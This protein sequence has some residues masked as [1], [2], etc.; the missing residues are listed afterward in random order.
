MDQAR[1]FALIILLTAAVGLVAVLSNRLSERLKIPVPLSGPRCRGHCRQ[2]DPQPARAAGANCR[3]DRHGR[4]D[5]HPVRRR[6]AHRRR[7]VPRSGAADHPG[8]RPGHVSDGGAAA[9][10]AAFGFNLGW[11]VAVLVATAVAPTDPAVVFSVLGQR[12]IAGRSGTILEGESGANDPVGIALMSSLIAAGALSAKAFGHVGVTF[13]LQMVIGALIGVIGG[14]AL[15]WFMRRVSLP[16]EGL[17]ALRTL[18]SAALLY[19]R[20]DGR[21][22][23]GLSR[24]V[25]RRHRDRR[26]AR[27][28][29]ARG[30]AISLGRVEPRRDRRVRRARTDRRHRRAQ[31]GERPG[32]R[33]RA[34][35][36]G[37][38][39]RTS[40]VRRAVP[41]CRQG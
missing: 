15:L 40:A 6:D 38:V 36:R 35:G 32:A 24:R 14:R 31:A 9:R 16:A 8:R 18:A 13:L 33:S 34:G 27:A 3:R 7:T 22:R 17:Y 4:P 39:R 20:C 1:H 19:R 26:R 2:G 29:Q 28:L 37:R 10:P 21:A 11:F 12:E 5:L 41:A 30:R 23:F 25:H